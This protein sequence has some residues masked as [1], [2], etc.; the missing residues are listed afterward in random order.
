MLAIPMGLVSGVSSVNK[1]G[2]N[3]VIDS[4]TS[5]EVWNGSVAYVYPA[6][7]LMTHVS[8]TA[9]QVAMRG[10]IIEAQG[11]DAN[12]DAVVQ[13]KALDA[14][15]TTTAV[16]WDTPMI[17]C[18]RMR[19]LANVV[20]ASPIRTHN[21]GETTD[22]AVISIGDNQTLMALYTVP[23]GKTA[24]MTRVYAGYAPTAVA[25][26]YSVD[27]RLWGA[28]RDNGYEFQIKHAIAVPSGASPPSDEF[29]PYKKFTQKTD[30]KVTAMPNGKAAAVHAGFDLILVDN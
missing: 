14:S 9:D 16:A 8:Q 15:L 19:V 21:V 4:N 5:E 3:L 27:F 25:N 7:V 2:E 29:R 10:A 24:Y 23:N 6:T 13:T 12:W 30:I 20:A 17:R 26:P 18:F 11:L 22:Y 1:F 28:D